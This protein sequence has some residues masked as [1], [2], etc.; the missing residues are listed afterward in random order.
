MCRHDCCT[1]VRPAFGM[2]LSL[3]IFFAIQVPFSRWWL[4]RFQM[5]PME[6][7]WRWL[8]YGQRES[9]GRLAREH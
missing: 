4:G 9:V 8:S 5:G 3:V 6:Y 2:L 7:P 1:V